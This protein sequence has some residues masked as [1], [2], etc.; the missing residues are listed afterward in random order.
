M[1]EP[2]AA[3]TAFT[4]ASNNYLALARVF[5]ESYRRHHPG[6]QVFV[7]IADRPDPRIDYAE[8]P[9]RVVFAEEL[10]IPAFASFA[11]RY[12]Q[13]EFSTA[14]KPWL[15]AWLRDRQGCDRALY[16]DPDILVGSRLVEI[17]AALA[18]HQ[19]ALTPHLTRPID[20]EHRPSERSIRMAGIY[21]L[22]FV[23]LRLDD[24]TAAFLSWWQ[25]RLYRFC[26]VD[27]H[28][29]LFVDQ[30]WM[31]FAPA[32]LDRVAVLRSPRLNVA[33]WNLAGRRIEQGAGGFTVESEPLG[34]FHFS[35]VPI[36]AGAGLSRHQDRVDVTMLPAVSALVEEYRRLALAA[37]H[38]RLRDLPYGFGRF[39]PDGPRVGKL[40]R[41]TLLRTDPHGRRFADPFDRADPDGFFTWL[42]E[43]LDFPLG[44]LTRAALALW[45]S[46][47]ELVARFPDL[48]H[49]DLPGFVAWLDE[50]RS[51]LAEELPAELVAGVELRESAAPHRV[52]YQQEPF[53][54]FLHLTRPERPEALEA[55]DLASPREWRAWLI[56]PFPGAGP[57]RP[58]LTRLGMLL[59]EK[60][61]PLQRAFPDPLGRDLDD[62]ALWL[63]RRGAEHFG[64]SVD[65][66]GELAL[67]LSADLAMRPP[68]EFAFETEA[69]APAT[70]PEGADAA[71]PRRT[72]PP[73]FG[74]QVLFAGRSEPAGALLARALLDA[75]AEAAVPHVEIDLDR[76]W[77][78][79]S[80]GGLFSSAEGAPWPVTITHLHLRLAP[81]RFGWLP[82]PATQGGRR[83]GYLDWDFPELPARYRARLEQWDEIWVPSRS[84]LAALGAGSPVPVRWVPPALL[85]PAEAEREPEPGTG[86]ARWV[87]RFRAGDPLQL[88]DPWTLLAALGHL[89]RSRPELSWSLDLH[90]EGFDDAGNPASAG[91]ETVAA[92]AEQA[93]GLP[94]RLVLASGGA[95]FAASLAGASALLVC[96][97]SGAFDPESVSAAAR[98]LPLAAPAAGAWLDLVDEATGY[99]LPVREAR[100]GRSAGPLPGS[101]RVPEVDPEGA[102][103][104]LA[105]LAADPVEAHR[106]AGRLR[107][108]AQEL[109]GRA[110]AARRLL[111]E[112]DRLRDELST[113]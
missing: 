72:R 46:R 8:L 3:L 48:A 32:F 25:E 2:G 15:F 28:H 93:A 39:R 24:S 105:A 83:I 26:L 30:S 40:L 77:L 112:L 100:L 54:N 108:R 97:R 37:G 57:E 94:V 106:R 31:D 62:L 18:G 9:F 87:A 1:T 52:P 53:R 78:G 60:H 113:G 85:D 47:P 65:L 6:A 111:V 99:P 67:R 102:A 91:A 71:P 74:V 84:A 14:I 80:V 64:L 35:G 82:A 23:G 104:V 38:D 7:G 16:F 49:R 22:G 73:A 75:L 95:D 21:N 5:A 110:S 81:W 107:R 56:E 34:F 13:L 4:I 19:A 63:A 86:A 69:P 89:A 76:D 33:Y 45:E 29:G 66:V 96:S 101:A 20:N 12:D 92:L 27:P 41:R 50:A 11:F 58:W 44:R 59:W 43:P 61:R 90:L 42:G 103:A 68:R 51:G 109:Y 70:P 79:Q 88:E 36:G 10:G 98:G 55:I 17:E